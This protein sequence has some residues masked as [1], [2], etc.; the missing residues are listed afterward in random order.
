MTCVVGPSPA[1]S[2]W[3]RGR[4]CRDG[5]LR[6]L[7]LT[8]TA[9]LLALQLA[10][11]VAALDPRP[12]ATAP[13]ALQVAGEVPHSLR[14]S[15]EDLARLPR[16][17]V[18]AKDHDGREVEFSGVTL[19]EVLRLAGAPA[20]AELKGAALAKYVVVSAADGYRVVFA[21]P[22]LSPDFTDAVV[23]LADHRDGKPLT[24]AE[25]PLRLVLPGEKRQ[26]RWVRQVV[27]LVVHSSPP[28][29]PD[30]VPRNP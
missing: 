12:P 1:V 25:G 9:P 20:G 19:A 10:A 8:L 3:A 18:H 27:S 16:T 28:D 23:L 2:Y 29:R 15:P 11:P 26:A 7:A 6:P 21:L 4:A 24:A 30:A 14:L 5:R 13:A 22:E 17:S